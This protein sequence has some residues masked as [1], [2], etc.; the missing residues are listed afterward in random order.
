[1]TPA[2]SNSNNNLIKYHQ[3]IWYLCM[4][5]LAVTCLLLV[6]SPPLGSE[7]SFWG[8]VFVLAATL[9][10]LFVMASDFRVSGKR[11]FTLLCYVLIAVIIFTTSLGTWLL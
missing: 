3:L 1:M 11:K 6:T 8:V 10:Q 9:S 2:N 4:A 7:M 5:Y